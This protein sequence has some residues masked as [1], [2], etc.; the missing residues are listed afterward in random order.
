MRLGRYIGANE[1]LK[2]ETAAL[3]LGGAG[4]V[5]VQFDDKATGLGFGWHRHPESDWEIVD[6]YANS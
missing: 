2:G 3:L 4:T 5:L 1:L 6:R